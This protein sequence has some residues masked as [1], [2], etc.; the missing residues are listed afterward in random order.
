M[1]E[2]KGFVFNKV[3]EEIHKFPIKNILVKDYEEIRET[4]KEMK[5]SYYMFLLKE[6]KG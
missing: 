4:M 3:G 1:Y 6:V 5:I 2:A